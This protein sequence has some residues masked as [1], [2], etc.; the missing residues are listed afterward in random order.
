MAYRI[1]V[2]CMLLNGQVSG[3]IT[4]HVIVI[5]PSGNGMHLLL[6]YDSK[7]MILLLSSS[8]C[9]LLPAHMLRAGIVFGSICLSAENLENY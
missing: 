3:S 9:M 5:L 7:Q 4:P 1:H 6:C 2:L 8:T